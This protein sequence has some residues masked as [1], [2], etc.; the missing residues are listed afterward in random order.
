MSGSSTS[1][2]APA[3][4]RALR[5]I[6]LFKFVKAL[7][8][9]ALAATAFGLLGEAARAGALEALASFAARLA[10]ATEFP[11]L[12]G[13]AGSLLERAL[14]ALLRW[15]GDATPTTLQI[16]GLVALAYG[17]VL[18]VEGTGLWKGKSWAEWFSVI[19]TGSLIPLELWEVTQRFTPVR[20][21]VLVLNVA[22]VWYLVQNLR[23]HRRGAAAG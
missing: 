15:L 7:T 9:V 20:V 23:A 1:V 17:V 21:G 5:A 12:R 11:G 16:T 14:S 13:W 19:V 10:R 3:E 2:T 6:A 18:G 4:R 22:V 8:C